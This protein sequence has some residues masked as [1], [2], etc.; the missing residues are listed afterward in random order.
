LALRIAETLK[1][2]VNAPKYVLVKEEIERL[3][4]SDEKQR[5]ELARG[6]V[7]DLTEGFNAFNVRLT[8][9][10]RPALALYEYLTATGI[11]Q[12]AFSS[13]DNTGN[14]DDVMRELAAI[15]QQWLN[16]QSF[17]Y[18]AALAENPIVRTAIKAGLQHPDQLWSSQLIDFI[19]DNTSVPA[20][21]V[22]RFLSIINNIE[23]VEISSDVRSN[24]RDLLSA[25]TSVNRSGNTRKDISY[26]ELVSVLGDKLSAYV[27]PYLNISTGEL[28]TKAKV[29][30]GPD[31]P[32]ALR[33][34]SGRQVHFDDFERI[35]V[36]MAGLLEHPDNIEL[37]SL[38]RN[39]LTEALS[40]QNQKSFFA[41]SLPQALDD[42]ETLKKIVDRYK[43]LS[44]EIGGPLEEDSYFVRQA[45]E[46]LRDELSAVLAAL[47]GNYLKPEDVLAQ[48]GAFNASVETVQ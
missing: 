35:E 45:K 4:V 31:W 12:E 26:R 43:E 28:V 25:N 20:Q 42:L 34:F 14:I 32:N 44:N 37:E 2:S 3:G 41:T 38:L 1:V 7:E 23:S 17:G 22:S 5:L 19:L 6:P 16:S 48:L 18:I 30:F 33:A 10:L 15:D 11:Y 29:K 8:Q 13:I 24:L 9:S 36:T 47:I 39:I 27:R 46:K 40:V 21:E